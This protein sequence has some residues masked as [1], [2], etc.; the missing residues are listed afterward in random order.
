MRL[1]R[2][3]KD[4]NDAIEELDQYYIRADKDVAVAWQLLDADES[5]WIDAELE[6]ALDLRYYLEN[7]HVITTEKSIVKSLYPFWDHQEILYE[8][9]QEEWASNICC[10]IIVLKPRQTGISVWTAASMFHRTIFNPHNFTMIVA[11]DGDTSGHLFKMSIDAYTYLPWWMKP[12]YMY[13]TKDG[14]IV[15]QR[16]DEAE[17]AVNPGLGSAI[18]VS[19]ANKTSG[20]A[21]GRTIK[22]LHASE[23]SRWPEGVYEGDIKPSM[24]APAVAYYAIMESTGFGRQGLFYD[25][26]K[27]ATRGDTDF[28]ALFIPVYKV[29]KYYLPLRLEE[30]DAFDLSEEE[31]HFNERIQK[32]DGFRIP[33]EFWNFR[34]RGLRAAKSSVDGK[35]GFLESYPLTP[36]EAFQA[37]GLCSF[38]RDSLEYQQMNYVCR[39]E[40]IGEINLVDIERGL[41]NTDSIREVT[42]DTELPARKSGRGG[43]RFWIW[44]MPEKDSQY[45]V[46]ADVAL[47]VAGGDY[48][49]CEVFRAGKGIEPDTQVAEWWGWIP[50]KRFAHTIAAI[51][52]FYG[53]ASGLPDCAEVAVEYMKDG[54]TTGNELRDMDYPNLYRP[55][56][57]DR[58]N[59]QA[60]NYLHWLTNSKTR[61]EIIGCMNEAL[62]E[63]VY[64]GGRMVVS[65]V[66]RSED[67]V[68]EM[69]DFA[70]IESEGRAEGQGNNDDGV[71]SSMIGLYCLRETLKHLKTKAVRDD[72]S[73]QTDNQ[74][75]N[76]GIFDQFNRPRGQRPNK[77]MAEKE[78]AGHPGWTVK[79]V[80]VCQANTIFSPIFDGAGAEAEL[81][82]RH[83]VAST[84]ITPDLVYAFKNAM[85]AFTPAGQRDDSE[86]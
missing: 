29:R 47:G 3:N 53:T 50:P 83:G 66:L 55:Q 1:P 52:L 56:F 72:T 38:D 54:I 31:T 58:I 26:W 18:H 85:Q 27:A 61:D 12:E 43:N 71:M 19:P 11:Q 10:K 28:R 33:R 5:A 22:N 8:A 48:S 75:K 59:H 62:L 7:Y 41:I 64:F 17:R 84:E 6:R 16:E 40:F 74:P 86:W 42:E 20:V 81:H 63:R 69:N 35:Q 15:F 57:K 82:S 32:E 39:P 34:R 9:I 79:P 78:C 77:A 23:A 24:N 46:S 49:V 70:A 68:D 67:L 4:L 37:S 80:L 65:V 21:I 30:Q 14:E 2:K 44:E 36:A 60:S 45:Y 13:K 76:W 73:R 25:Q 51:G